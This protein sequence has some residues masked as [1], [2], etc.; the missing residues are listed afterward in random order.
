VDLT[1]RSIAEISERIVYLEVRSRLRQAEWL[2]YVA[3]FDRREAARRRGFSSTAAWLAFECR[4]DGRTARD[5][6]RVARRL[7]EMPK[8]AEAFGLGRL[9]YSQARALSR[10]EAV[11]DE[12][13]L[14]R[15]ALNST[16]SELERHVRQ[17]RSAP[18][19][20]LDV[21][22]RARA[23]RHLE[24]FWD[25]D[26]SLR[27][28]GRLASDEG[29]AL[30]EAL[31]TRAATIYGEDGD[32][33]CGE[34]VKRP[35]VSARRADALVEL[36][37]GGGVQTQLVLHADVEALACAAHGEEPRSGEILFLRDGPAIPSAVARRL[38]CDAMVSIDG[39]NLGRSTR[40]VSPAQRRALE[41]RDGRICSIAGCERTHGLQAHHLR[42]WIRGGRTDL[43]NLALFCHF[44]HRLFHDFGWSVR[45][46]LDG[47]LVIRDP[48]GREV[49]SAVSRPSRASPERLA[50]AA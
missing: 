32:P 37:T 13:E 20:D 18:S 21:A 31:E 46:Q 50:V 49:P 48:K 22:N 28:F 36:V 47:T 6:V 38:T 41:A 7:R 15:L 10:V 44:H 9:S 24:H 14:L 27:F 4:M 2:E 23:R 45:R 3:E 5:H 29:A 11:E 25:E 1:D 34:G 39:L 16:T 12:G 30:I 42:H 40:L 26:G 33:C 8:V 35:S 19:A 43:D 17:L